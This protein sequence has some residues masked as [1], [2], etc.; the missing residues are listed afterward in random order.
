M[1]FGTGAVLALPM[2]DVLSVYSP[3]FGKVYNRIPQ[4]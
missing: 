1:L 4:T 3:V 2:P